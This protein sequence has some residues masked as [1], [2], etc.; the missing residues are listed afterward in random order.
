MTSMRKQPQDHLLV[1]KK[2]DMRTVQDLRNQV[3]RWIEGTS[4]DR[5]M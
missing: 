3:H 1:F 2:R 4:K 5:G